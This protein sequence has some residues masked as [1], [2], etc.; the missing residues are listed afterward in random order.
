MGFLMADFTLLDANNLPTLE[1]NPDFG[2]NDAG[3][4]ATE[5]GSAS[6]FSYSDLFGYAG[7]AVKLYGDIRSVTTNT[8]GTQ[9]AQPVTIPAPQS[10]IGRDAMLAPTAGAGFFQRMANKFAVSLN[11]VYAVA[12]VIALGVA[13]IAYKIFRR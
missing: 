6:G 13:F 2:Y 12:G 11:T 8:S 10:P 5:G 3:A 4:V 9:V 1:N 7:Q